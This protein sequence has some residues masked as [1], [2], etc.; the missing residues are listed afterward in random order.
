[1]WS[2]GAVYLIPLPPGVVRH[3]PL[4]SLRGYFHSPA[5]LP[6]Y[7]YLFAG[8]AFILGASIGSFLNV[9]I[10]RLPRDLSVNNPRR[11]FCPACNHPIPWTQNLP[12]ISWLV[13]RGK[14]AKC[15]AP[16][17]F[18]YFAVELITALLFLAV[19]LHVWPGQWVLA[20][21]FWI[22]VSLFIVATFIDFE[23]FIIPDEITWGG[24]AAG[25][26]LSLAMPA[27]QGVESNLMA[28]IWSVVGAAA[29]YFTLWGVVELGKKA[30]GKKRLLFDPPKSFEWI[31]R[32]EDADFKL[33]DEKE[34]WSEFFARES[35]QMR[36]HCPEAKVDGETFSDALL[37]FHYNRLT[38]GERTWELIKVDEISGHAREIV[39][40]REAM[41]FG[42]VKFI[43]AIGAFLG[44][45]AVFFTVL[46]ASTLGA[47]IGL[48]T[49][50]VG[51]RDWS[52]KIP[53]GPYLALG[54]LIWLFA[55]P[56]IVAWYWRLAT[57]PI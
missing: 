27:L 46:A 41:G 45:K 5:V 31:R 57:P 7:E 56:Q 20:I 55:G 11:S 39:I 35:D 37:V 50:A 47:V 52:A 12:L 36:L 24:V 34:P 38:I 32:G 21:P 1:M 3:F 13:L 19:W 9:C 17:A 51:R 25:I 4:S 22:L 14:C 23:H 43:A 33:G 18:R 28:G 48:A 6:V 53:F 15:G 16:I 49:I 29:G 10:Y 44:W 54:A 40:P 8:F 26:V 2:S 30:F 42:D